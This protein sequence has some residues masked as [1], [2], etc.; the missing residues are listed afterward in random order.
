MNEKIKQIM[1]YKPSDA[2]VASF[3]NEA[4]GYSH[5]FRYDKKMDKIFFSAL[6]HKCGIIQIYVDSTKEMEREFIKV[7]EGFI[8]RNF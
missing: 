8:G 3:N 1:S 2:F 4:D 5:S 6:T 7:V